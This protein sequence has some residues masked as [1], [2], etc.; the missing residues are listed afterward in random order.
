MKIVFDHQIFSSQAYGG[1]SRYFVRLAQDLKKLNENINV[2]APVYTN[3]YLKELPC[4]IVHGFKVTHFPPK[5]G[6]II[7]SINNVVTSA[8]LNNL[9]LDIFH[10]TYYSKAAIAQN[11]KIRILTVYDMIHEK[12]GNYFS[13]NDQTSKV[14]KLAV[15][16]ADHIIAISNSTKND[17]CKLFNVPDEKVSV[18]HLGFD[19]IL[20]E[21][22]SIKISIYDRPY[23]LYVG[24]R[25]GYKNF[26]K[27]LK[28]FASNYKL[29]NTFNIVAFGGGTFSSNEK[30]LIISLGLSFESVKQIGGDDYVLSALYKKARAFVYPSLYEGF[31]LP[32]LEAMAHDCPVV[33]SNTSSV[34]EVV[35]SAGEYFDPTD[36]ESITVAICKVVFDYQRSNELII[37]GRKRLSQFSWKRC[38][39]ETRDVYRKV[40]LSKGFY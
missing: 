21:S 3:N 1:T 39:L 34:P 2:V 10:E 24:S 13:A 4:N 33:V 26:E 15:Q 11:A 23:L 18:V 28:S 14:K 29:K 35:G 5:T 38:A 31:G 40:L 7:R 8:Y 36:V 19:S 9:K 30:K 20:N 17:L 6:R 27:L 37:E 16:R 12:F 32:P 25:S 22:N